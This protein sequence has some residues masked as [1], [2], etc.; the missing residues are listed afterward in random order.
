MPP[1]PLLSARWK[2]DL[3]RALFFEHTHS[4]GT[5]FCEKRDLETFRAREDVV[6]EEKQSFWRRLIVEEILFADII[7]H[8]VPQDI[9]DYFSE[10]C[11][12]NERKETLGELLGRPAAMAVVPLASTEKGGRPSVAHVWHV[13]GIGEAVAVSAEPFQGRSMELAARLAKEAVEKN[14][15]AVILRL[16]TLW[17]IT[18]RMNEDR[19]AS[20]ELGDKLALELKKRKW[21]IPRDNLKQVSPEMEAKRIIRSADSI[22]TA[23]NQVSGDGTT[24]SGED[25]WPTDTDELHLLVGGNIKAQVA[26][27]LLTNTDAKIV[28]WHSSNETFSKQPAKQIQELC[29]THG[30]TCVELREL[31]DQKISDAEK[32]L[33]AYFRGV[34]SSKQILF[35]VTS[36]NR[37]MS[38]AVQ[39]LARLRP[40]IELIYRELGEQTPHRFVRLRYTTFPPDSGSL[41]GNPSPNLSVNW[42]FLYGG[43]RS[44]PDEFASKL[45]KK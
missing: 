28:L 20:I 33:R 30:R 38:Y 37:L 9:R 16:A 43:E 35:N 19:V 36:G 34:S 31:S 39:A 5:L 8:S 24:E 17:I 3:L 29:E 22:S 13:S 15:S 11:P 2:K 6:P 14:D 40:E 27:I 21:L 7:G 12:F 25:A 10:T 41:L 1:H 18:G 26:S 4:F 23:W 32:T 44:E 45:W 42:S